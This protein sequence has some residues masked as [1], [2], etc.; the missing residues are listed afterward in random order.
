MLQLPTDT[1]ATAAPPTLARHSERAAAF[2]DLEG[3]I[4]DCAMMA[5]IAAQYLMDTD[6]RQYPPELFFAVTHASEMIDALKAKYY[7][8]YQS[9]P[10]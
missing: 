2:Q 6:E 1:V 3:A 10:E 5:R 7:A 8:H 9:D 4:C